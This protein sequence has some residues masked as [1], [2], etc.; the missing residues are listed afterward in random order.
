VE[1]AAAPALPFSQ[2]G[3]NEISIF[4]SKTISMLLWPAPTFTLKRVG[5]KGNKSKEGISNSDHATRIARWKVILVCALLL[6]LPLIWRWTPLEH[7]VNLRTILEWQQSLRSHPA[8]PFY[9]I[10]AYLIGSLVFFPITIL[11]LA[12]VFAF[13]PLWGNIYSSA[14]W[15]LGAAQGFLLG[16]LIGT[17]SLHQLAGRRVA[18][19]ID[20]AQHHGFLT[21][22]AMRVLPVAPFSLVNMFIGA[23]G[24]RLVDFL[25]ASMVGR[26]PGVLTL[27][28]FGAQLEYAMRKPGLISYALVIA[29]IIIGS[30]IVPR[31]FRRLFR[32]HG[33]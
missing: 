26:I 8:A 25:L 27:T 31:L 1:C 3:S 23:S 7:W 18:H 29:A 10:A 17:E 24:I 19:L 20:Q 33:G 28:L 9:V 32:R 13:G 21:V 4:L 12:T 15:L 30:V 5:R 11:T 2:L 16:R 14:G 6:A 22:L